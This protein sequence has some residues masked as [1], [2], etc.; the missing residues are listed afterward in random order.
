MN[1][2][3]ALEMLT[4]EATSMFESCLG[5]GGSLAFAGGMHDAPTEYRSIAERTPSEGAL[6]AFR[7]SDGSVW[8]G[9]D[10]G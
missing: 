4:A 7:E 6:E 10:E 3:A 5:T 8:A 9:P 1:P 2:L